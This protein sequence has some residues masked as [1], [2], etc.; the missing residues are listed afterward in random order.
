M[1]ED[2]EANQ[3]LLPAVDGISPILAMVEQP[4]RT[5]LDAHATLA[6]S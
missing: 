1:N 5:L 2:K 3:S 4:N 6:E